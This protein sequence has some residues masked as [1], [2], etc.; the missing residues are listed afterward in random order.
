MRQ[1]DPSWDFVVALYGRPGVEEACLALQD[2]RGADVVVVLGLIQ[3]AHVGAAPA[4]AAL[5]R[6]LGKA[7]WWQK[8]I[9]ETR[10][11]RRSLKSEDV[12]EAARRAVEGAERAA[13]RAELAI[14][15]QALNGARDVSGDTL[16]DAARSLSAYWRLAGLAHDET[17]RAQLA[18]LVSQAFPDQA[19]RAAGAVERAFSD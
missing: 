5:S 17:D 16:A 2:R 1:V 18:V 9:R 14:F 4:G 7:A 13:E 19:A 12:P 11:V 8:S 10:A 6:A 3:R 15:L